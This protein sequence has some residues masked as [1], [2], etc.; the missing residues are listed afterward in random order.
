MIGVRHTG[1][2]RAMSHLTTPTRLYTQDSCLY[3]CLWYT[4]GY[5]PK[6]RVSIIGTGD[7]RRYWPH[8]ITTTS[9]SI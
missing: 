4:N 7:G 1:T 8:T 3:V 5:R 6:A 9:I 2:V